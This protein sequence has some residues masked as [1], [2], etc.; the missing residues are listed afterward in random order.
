M[1]KNLKQITTFL[2]V[3]DS[4]SFTKAAD[5]LGMSRSMVSIDIKQLEIRLNVSL[6][7]RNTRNI[8]LTEAG[9]HFYDD[10]KRIQLEIEEAFERSQNLA[11][12][13]TGLLRFSSTNEFGQRYIL[14]LLPE[15]CRLY[16]KLR[17]QYSFNS[18][19]DDLVTEKLDLAIRLGNLKSSSL[20]IRK[21]GEYQ[22]YIVATPELLKHYP[23]KG[24][25][26]L[27][28]IP[29]I[30]H[31]LLNW[32]DTQYVLKNTLGEKYPLPIIKSQYESNS[33]A[34]IQQMVLASLGVAICPDWLV[35]DDINAGRLIRL[36]P[37][38]YLPSQ[39]I[40]LLYPNS[41]TLPAK[42]RVFIDYLVEKFS[43]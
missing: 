32:Q 43:L 18:S 2:Q 13:V 21:I 3:V 19:L 14:P 42:T 29:W 33:V 26:D 16:P 37:E 5:I 15:F 35:N 10:F 20:K 23:V 8:A 7:I 31:S 9:K 22:I 25:N 11:T 17:L 4:G 34:V 40:Q 1:Q 24:I 30:T 28:Q 12:N 6:L 38:F 36:L 39:N 41:I 27:A